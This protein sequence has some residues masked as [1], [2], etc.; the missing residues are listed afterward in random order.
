MFDVIV[1]GG[2]V[3]GGTVL[4]E[5]TKY[6][7]DVCLLERAADVCMGQSKANSGIVHA[8]FDAKPGTLKARFNVLGNKMMPSYAKELGVK[9]K[10]NGSLVVAFT[11]EDI[12]TLAELKERGEKN[13][14]TIDM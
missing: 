11:D 2:G 14:E 10:N 8:G 7:L 12:L 3:I 4:R 6:K 9:Y 1:I 13:L 5:L